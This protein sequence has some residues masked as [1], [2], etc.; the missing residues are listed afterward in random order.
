MEKVRYIHRLNS[1]K[2]PLHGISQERL[3]GALSCK[4]FVSKYDVGS[5][6][7][8][9]KNLVYQNRAWGLDQ[10]A[11]ISDSQHKKKYQIH[12]V[13]DLDNNGVIVTDAQ[14]TTTYSKIVLRDRSHDGSPEAT[15]PHYLQVING[16]S[17]KDIGERSKKL[18]FTT[19]GYS[20]PGDT[21]KQG[22]RAVELS[23]VSADPE[24]ALLD[25]LLQKNRLFVDAKQL[26]EFI[27]DPF[28]YIPFGFSDP[29]EIDLWWKYWFQVVDRGLR[30]K[31]IPQP[32]QTA[33][34]GFEGFF[35]HTIH[36]S[37]E[38]AKECGYTHLTAVPTWS[39]VLHAFLENGFIPTNQE[40]FEE[41]LQF[42]DALGK[43]ELPN[44]NTLDSYHP[45]DPLYSWLAVAPF[46]IELNPNH[47]PNLNIDK[48]RVERFNLLFQNL[49]KSIQSDSKVLTYPLAPGRNFWLEKKL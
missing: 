2:N 10:T 30:G 3:L 47:V 33:Q 6:K 21:L 8:G 12:Y 19:W 48:T 15:P 23:I 40:Q 34:R 13:T 38:I 44:G 14:N 26:A 1:E 49:K 29:K 5:V 4:G 20:N 45:K 35:K 24:K 32:G 7:L 43:T 46:V 36:A 31:E 28:S 41:A 37:E 39:Y 17:A 11:T 25:R 16:Y 18:A 27:D 42:V 22:Q 9:K